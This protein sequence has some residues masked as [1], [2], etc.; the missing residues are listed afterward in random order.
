MA[1][2]FW[3]KKWWWWWCMR[4]KRILYLLP[5]LLR[6]LVLEWKL[7]VTNILWLGCISVIQGRS[8]T[9]CRILW[10]L[11]SLFVAMEDATN[12]FLLKFFW[13][14]LT[15][16]V[17]GQKFVGIFKKQL[18]KEVIVK[19]HQ[20]YPFLNENFHFLFPKK[21]QFSSWLSEK[22]YGDW[23]EARPGKKC[24]EEVLWKG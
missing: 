19:H 2:S 7:L 3:N 1:S 18:P 20:N 8:G 10:W 21:A 6:H 5:T 11:L 13:Y 17:S 9:G 14:K 4:K 22:S 23:S 24:W 16:N 15:N 12:T